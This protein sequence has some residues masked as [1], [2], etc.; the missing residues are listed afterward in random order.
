MSTTTIRLPDQLR[1]RLASLA[2]RRG[3]SAHALIIEA[4]EAHLD[5][6]ERWGAFLDEARLADR[7]LDDGGSAY[8]ADAVHEYLDALARGE[9]P[10]RPSSCRA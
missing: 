6:E 10:P 1:P 3:T 9:R 2:D 8:D 7:E 4:V 5:R